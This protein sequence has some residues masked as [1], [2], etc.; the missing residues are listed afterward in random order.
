VTTSRLDEV[1]AAAARAEARRS[2]LLSVENVGQGSDTGSL[3]VLGQDDRAN[4]AGS[5][6]AMEA[7]A[8]DSGAE[9]NEQSEKTGPEE[10]A[11]APEEDD[12]NSRG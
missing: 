3:P 7:E 10:G 6:E 1:L 9:T 12:V 4:E 2:N 8:V 11:A 5:S